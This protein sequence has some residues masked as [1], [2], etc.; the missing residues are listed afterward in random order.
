M[1]RRLTGVVALAATACLALSGCGGSSK[2]S[3]GAAAAPSNPAD[4]SGPITVLTN[5]TDLKQDGTLKK[6]AAE[7]NKVYPK[8][9]V[10]FQAITDYETEVKTRMN[11][12]NYGDV[13]L[14]PPSISRTD[15]PKFFESLGDANSLSQKY[16]WIDTTTVDGTTDGKA[17]GI[18]TFGN[19]N[20]F[21]YNKK[22]W[23]AAGVTKYPTTPAQFVSD[24]QAIK[25]KGGSIPY[26]TNYHDG[27]PVQ[28][29]SGALGSTDCDTNANAELATD[30]TPWS[31]DKGPGAIYSLLFTVAQDKLIEPDPTTTNWENS[32]TLLGTGKVATMWLG[33]WAVTQMQAAAKKAGADPVDIGFMP[34]PAQKDGKFCSVTGPDYNQAISIHSSRKQAARAWL[35]WFTDKSGFATDQGSIPTQKGAQLPTTLADYQKADVTYI[36]LA[37]NKAGTVTKIDNESEVG[38]FSAPSTAQ[39]VVDVARGVARGTMD[40]LFNGL[41]KKWADGISTV[42]G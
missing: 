42:G 20:G 6:Y 21:V 15:Y 35:D 40:S 2:S 22:V 36:E 17:Y 32:K 19:A 16:N 34:F 24:L 10:T 14:I 9:T 31:A 29:W 33:S 30:K 28:S 27:W 1:N 7:F 41:N 4:V 18:A 25:A 8:V 38:F 13:L 39:Q 26:Y 37:Q 12:S 5:R 23:Q 11:T 3:G